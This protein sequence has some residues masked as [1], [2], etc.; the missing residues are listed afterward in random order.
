MLNLSNDLSIMDGAQTITWQPRTTSQTLTIPGAVPRASE[1]NAPGANDGSHQQYD[2]VWHLPASEFK[3]KQTS[4]KSGDEFVDAQGMV[5][6]VLTAELATQ[7]SRWKCQTR[8]FE[9]DVQFDERVTIQQAQHTKDTTGA[10]QRSWVTIHSNVPA[11]IQTLAAEI[12]DA[13]QAKAQRVNVFI[14]FACEQTLE[15]ETR[16]V[17]NGGQVYQVTGYERP[18]QLDKYFVLTAT[19]IVWPLAE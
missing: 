7:Q 18:E 1:Q 11:R 16:I 19:Q 2:L 15:R 17:A 4:P 14:Y 6:T 12:A 3:A 9:L 10:V 13:H 8:R 5:W